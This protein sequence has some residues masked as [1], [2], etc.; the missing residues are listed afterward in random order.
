MYTI[1]KNITSETDRYTVKRKLYEASLIRLKV[2]LNG[3]DDEDL[4]LDKNNILSAL[5]SAHTTFKDMEIER[6]KACNHIW[7]IDQK[8]RCLCVRCGADSKAL[9]TKTKGNEIDYAKD[10]L[11]SFFDGIDLENLPGIEV[12]VDG[13]LD[14][15]KQLFKEVSN[16]N[17][18]SSDEELVSKFQ[19]QLAYRKTLKPNENK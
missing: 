12:F 10:A 16:N 14:S 2:L 13:N 17:P 1:N 5:E 4:S 8:D 18:E 3:T 11:Y 19:A 6:Y 15:M 9:E 7:F